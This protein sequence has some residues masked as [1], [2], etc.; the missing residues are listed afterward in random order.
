MPSSAFMLLFLQ[1]AEEISMVEC[2][3][4]IQGDGFTKTRNEL[5]T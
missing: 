2:K 5:L 1:A 3:W 4:R